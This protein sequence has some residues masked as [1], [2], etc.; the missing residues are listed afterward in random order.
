MEELYLNLDLPAFFRYT[1]SAGRSG[2]T[3][4]RARLKIVFP[5]GVWVRFP[6][7]A[8]HELIRHNAGRMNESA[9]R[10]ALCKSDVNPPY[11]GCRRRRLAQAI[12]PKLWISREKL[13]IKRVNWGKPTREVFFLSKP[14]PH[15]W[16]VMPEENPGGFETLWD[17]DSGEKR[18]RSSTR[19]LWMKQPDLRRSTGLY[20]AG[21][22]RERAT[23]G[24]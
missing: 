24:L 15:I 7:S 10:C 18:S 1:M 6:P 13:W 12:S 11:M 21:K 3:G 23:L 5:S 9:R 14:H 8:H 16:G 17:K 20:L 22:W 2:G 19:G 4:R